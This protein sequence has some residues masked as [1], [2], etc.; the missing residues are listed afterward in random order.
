MFRS[1]WARFF[2]LLLAVT[3]LGL[4][5]SFYLRHMMLS[6]FEQYMEGEMLDRV[7]LVTAALEGGYER[8]SGW[9]E[10]QV[11]KELIRALMM[12][13]VT[14]VFDNS[15]RKLI[16]TAE[17]VEGL[18]PFMKR[19][20]LS[21]VDMN[22]RTP[23]GDPVPFPLFLGGERIG[24]LE[25]RFFSRDRADLFTRRSVKFLMIAFVLLGGL[26]VTASLVFSRKLTSPINKLEEQTR[27]IR[28]GDYSKRADI[29]DIQE[30]GSLS[31]SFNEMAD[32]LQLLESLRRKLISNIA[33]ELRTPLAAMT[34]EL[35]AMADE[36]LP[37]DMDRVRSLHE[38][39]TRLRGH[40]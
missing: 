29:S 9:N 27:S 37:L 10:D 21:L 4:S 31:R 39:T 26:A 25:V 24:I 12:G 32:D 28:E 13:M 18:T 8:R 35:E 15:G 16:D 34:A 38:E 7:Y 23:S 40:A 11:R 22:N 33:H 6:D 30:I 2:I 3:L 14:S 5:A 1:L 36:I 19:R 17:A 20:V